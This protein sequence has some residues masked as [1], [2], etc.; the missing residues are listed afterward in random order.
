MDCDSRPPTRDHAHKPK[1]RGGRL[2]KKN[3][4]IV[5]APCN[6]DKGA[7]ALYEW[8][9]VLWCQKDSRAG[10]VGKFFPQETGR[11]GRSARASVANSLS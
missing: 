4:K 9:L 8:F 1:S 11:I 5:C 10:I 6:R 7:L 3:R 2:G